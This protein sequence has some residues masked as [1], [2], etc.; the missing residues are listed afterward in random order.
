[1]LKE[2]V[3]LVRL[4]ELEFGDPGVQATP[5]RVQ[6]EI[7]RCRTEITPTVLNRYERLKQRFRKAALAEASGRACSGCR[8]SIPNTMMTRLQNGLVAVCDNCGR[9]VYNPD[10]VF[11]FRF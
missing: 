8:M 11:L 3:A 6:A 9:L 4:H 5:E 7:D 2:A 10:S 1:M